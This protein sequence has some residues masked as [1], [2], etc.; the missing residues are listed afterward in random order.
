MNARLVP[1]SGIS[2]RRTLQ[3]W[4]CP[5]GHNNQASNR[6]CGECG[7]DRIQ[8]NAQVDASE[9]VVVYRHPV[10]GEFKRPPRA[11]APMPEKY[12]AQGFQREEVFSMIQHEKETGSVHEASNF[13][14]GNE[15]SPEREIIPQVPKAVKE[16]LIR[17]IMDAHQSGKWTMDTPLVDGPD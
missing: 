5:F 3:S 10:T 13:T 11:D 6:L 2:G 17:D 12:A 14:A 9:R 4:T 8:R 1:A 7:H 15:P 16:G